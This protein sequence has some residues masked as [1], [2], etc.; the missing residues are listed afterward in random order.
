M[1]LNRPL[2]VL[3]EY[4]GVEAQDIIDLQQQAIHQVETSRSSLVMGSALLQQHGLGASFRLPSLFTNIHTLLHLDISVESDQGADGILNHELVHECLRSA[5]AHVLADIKYR[6]RI[7]VPGSYTLL[8]VSDEADCL[9]EKQIYATIQDPRTGHRQPILGRVAIT[10]SPQIHPGDIQ[11]V[12]AVDHP[13]L[14]HLTN[15]VVFS[16]RRVSLAASSTFG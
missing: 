9:E 14:H 13:S 7:P 5:A 1:F 16:C 3:L 2:I 8:G 15:V 10:R 4:L 11:M 6:A 12:D